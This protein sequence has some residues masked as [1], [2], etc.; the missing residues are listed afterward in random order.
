M[1]F[2]FIWNDIS[3]I[4][5]KILFFRITE[6]GRTEE[7]KILFATGF[8]GQCVSLCLRHRGCFLRSRLKVGL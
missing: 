7:T 4:R 5:E 3:L 2:L 1:K 6:V 8:V